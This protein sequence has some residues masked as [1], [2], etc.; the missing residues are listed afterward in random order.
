MTR[1]SGSLV[2]KLFSFSDQQ[3]IGL[4]E[5]V[6]KELIPE[7][8]GVAA[9]HKM[10]AEYHQEEATPAEVVKALK[11]AE[12]MAEGLLVLMNELPDES[13][14]ILFQAAGG[15]N[16]SDLSLTNLARVLSSAQHLAQAQ[17]LPGRPPDK[18]AW[19]MIWYTAELF[20]AHGLEII[21]SRKSVFVTT[22]SLLLDSIKKHIE[23]P[24]KLAL[25]VL[26]YRRAGEKMG[27]S[28]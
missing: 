4:S 7:L 9:Q 13:D 25:R 22:I 18:A 5:L 6:G 11:R 21:K 17:V 14:L 1:R 20:E 8:E 26:K 24:F 28:D 15:S 27:S 23:D 16:W 3:R 10:F 19:S 2:E 12:E